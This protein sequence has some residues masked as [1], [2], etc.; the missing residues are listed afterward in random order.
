M[1]TNVDLLL[2]RLEH[3]LIAGKMSRR[4]FLSAALATGLMG[5][6]P[7]RAL[8]DELDDMRKI[9]ADKLSKLAKSYD[10]IVIGSGSSGCALVGTL[11]AKTDATILLIEAGDWDT[12]PT[13]DDPRAW[14]A[15]LGTERDW[16]DAAIPSAGVNNRAI[17][18]HMGRVVGG[19]SS[20]NATIWSRPIKADMDHWASVTGDATWNY[21]NS[22]KIF[23][24]IENWQ[25]KPNPDFRGTSG[26]VWVQ[27]AQN[28]LPLVDATL[29]AAAEVGLPVT[30]DLNT[31]RELSGSGFGLMNQIIKDGR[32]NSLARAYLYPVLARNNVTLLVKTSAN[33]II[34]EGDKA[35]GVECVRNGETVTFRA[36]REIIVAAGGFNTPKLLML[37]GIGDEAELKKV[38]IATT[39]NA[40]E[41]GKN[42]QDHIL[43]GGCLFES[44]DPIEH[45]N[46]AANMSGYLKTDPSLELP[47][48]SIVQIELP[49]TSEVIGKEYPPTKPQNTWA[50]C[51]GLVAPKSRG[52][53]KL[54][55]N[56]PA[57][58]PIVDMQFL[59]HPDDVEYLG[60]AIKVAREIAHA[61]ALKKYVVREVAPG[62]ELKGAELANFI[63]NGATT[64]FHASGACRMGNDDKAVVDSQLRVKGVRNLRIADSTIMPRIVSV[65]TMP[66]CALIGVRMADFL[67]S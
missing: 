37:S 12:A 1:K 27:P 26:P 65:P 17:P 14:F 42:V 11:A 48:V 40:S 35:V 30:D 50:L 45:R 52:T 43:H 9:Q 6:M 55:S 7:L 32:R 67:L 28:L 8:A 58:R 33:R 31:D 41:V 64:Y 44:P 36:E 15:N 38:S 19:G 60:R 54:A 2:E 3:S 57:D 51:G 10:Y 62:K 23:K 49:Y 39:L 21:D 66:V 47:D 63:R 5:V 24:R 29:K 53:V 46:S 20:I 59:S 16:G 18:E 34:L 4:T 22:L 13:V 56:K 25:G 61:P